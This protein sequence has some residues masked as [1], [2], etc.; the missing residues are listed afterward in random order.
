MTHVVVAAWPLLL[1]MGL[2]M[3]GGGLQG[4]LLGLRAT[5][6]G[7]PPSVTGVVMACY[8]LGYLGGTVLAPRFVQRVGHIRVFA[9]FTSMAST[10][11]LLQAV[12]VQPLFWALLRLASGICFAGIY[13]VAE[14]WLNDRATSRDRGSLLAIYMVV[15][16]VGLGCAQFLLLLADP[17]HATLFMLTSVL[18]SLALVPTALSVQPAPEFRMPAKIGF[19]ELYRGSP[20]GVVGVLIAGMITG[21][22]FSVGPVYAR[23][24]GLDTRGVAT[25]MGV[26]ILAA[27][28]TQYPIGRLSD[29]MDRRTV[30]AWVCALASLVATAV[31]V[32]REP[33]LYVLFPLA[34]VFGGLALTLYSLALSH[35]N[36]HLE[37]SQMVAASGALILLNGAGAAI[38]PV[39]VG[40]LMEPFGAQA[41]FASLAVLAGLLA[42]FDL[43]RKARRAPVPAEQ[44]GPFLSAQPQAASGRMVAGAAEDRARAAEES[45]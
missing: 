43:W 19:R 2:L 42:L 33:P 31:V 7:F 18:I 3:L 32:L 30:I 13:V 41:Y 21:T 5:L 12:F 17:R 29:R 36:D 8:Y 11:I 14:S 38:G 6:E 16:Y 20:L 23:L 34:A 4:T 45:S 35:V 22:L 44:K 26:S 1:G 40:F 39:I 10:A 9:A 15:L 24:S 27:V 37:P 28:L 25:F